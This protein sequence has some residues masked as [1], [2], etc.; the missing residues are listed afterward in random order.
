MSEDKAKEVE[1]FIFIGEEFLKMFK[2]IDKKSKKNGKLSDF[3]KK[4][5]KPRKPR[6][7][8]SRQN[9]SH[10]IIFRL[11][12]ITLKRSSNKKQ[13]YD[14]YHFYI[15]YFFHKYMY[16]LECVCHMRL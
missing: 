6:K 8:N 5:R 16:D 4:I 9:L 15:K 7:K 14:N 2:R 12:K 10:G 11:K 13:K 1:K 3:M